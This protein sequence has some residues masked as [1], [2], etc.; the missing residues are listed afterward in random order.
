MFY[1]LSTLLITLIIPE[2]NIGSPMIVAFIRR[3]DSNIRNL[4]AVGL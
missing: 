4:M 2:D 1:I 3:H